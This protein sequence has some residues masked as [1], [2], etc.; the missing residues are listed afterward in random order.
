M[1][2]NGIPASSRPVI[3]KMVSIYQMYLKRW[4]AFMAER[5]TLIRETYKGF[6]LGRRSGAFVTSCVSSSSSSTIVGS[7]V[8]GPIP[9]QFL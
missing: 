5:L 2:P 6:E 4:Q 8:G 1:G 3:E 9:E 7:V